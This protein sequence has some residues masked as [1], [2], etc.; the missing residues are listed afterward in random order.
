MIP[1]RTWITRKNLQLFRDFEQGGAVY[2]RGGATT[3]MV[4]CVVTGNSCKQEGGGTCNAD[5]FILGPTATTTFN[6]HNC[7]LAGN[8]ADTPGNQGGGHLNRDNGVSELINCT[9]VLNEAVGNYGGIENVGDAGVLEVQNCIVWGNTDNFDD[10]VDDQLHFSGDAPGPNEVDQNVVEACSGCFSGSGDN[11]GGGPGEDPDVVNTTTGMT[12][13]IC[14]YDADTGVSTF[15][16]TVDVT[17]SAN[18]RFFQPESTSPLQLLIKTVA[19]IPAGADTISCYGKW[20]DLH[21]GDPKTGTIYDYH[22]A[23]GSSAIDYGST[24]YLADAQDPCDLNEANGTAEPLPKDLDL[25][26]RRE[27]GSNPDS[28]AYEIE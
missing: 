24:T 20:L 10:G 13:V 8:W 3:T 22:I 17:A 28:G 15:T 18:T 21:T 16:M 23:S 5:D 1:A 14:T 27:Q 9:V 19:V 25:N 7:L 11:Q 12:W 6:L 26:D 4:N 2:D